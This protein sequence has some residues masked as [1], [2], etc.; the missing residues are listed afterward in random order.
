M[1]YVSLII[2]FL[3]GRPAAVFWTAAL[4]QAVLWTLMPALVYAAPPG[5]VPLLLAIGHEFVLGS[6]LG[7]PLSFWL[8][9]LAYRIAGAFGSTRWRRAAS[10]SPTGPCSRSAAAS[11]A[12]ATRCSPCC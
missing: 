2:E 8:G 12:Y 11:S 10:S 7:P 5:G 9:E 3:R 1:H 4:A 6:Y